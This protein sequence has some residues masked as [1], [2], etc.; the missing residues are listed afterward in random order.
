MKKLGLIILLHHH[1]FLSRIFSSSSHCQNSKLGKM[2]TRDWVLPFSCACPGGPLLPAALVHHT[3]GISPRNAT[4]TISQNILTGRFH[5]KESQC[6]DSS[7]D[8]LQSDLHCASPGGES[9]GRVH[10][11]VS[12]LSPLF[13]SHPKYWPHQWHPRA[14]AGL[15]LHW[16]EG[17][18]SETSPQWLTEMQETSFATSDQGAVK[19]LYC[20]DRTQRSLWQ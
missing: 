18:F 2:W 5:S 13:P 1:S 3:V 9:R 8:G 15:C 6:N 20:T 7:C 10:K 11:D 4:P 14:P 12:I 16:P 17:S 19:L